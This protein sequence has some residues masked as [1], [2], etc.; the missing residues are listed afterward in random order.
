ME[1]EDIHPYWHLQCNLVRGNTFIWT[2]KLT[3]LLLQ[4]DIDCYLRI[5]DLLKVEVL[6]GRPRGTGPFAFTEPRSLPSAQGN[7][8]I[9]ASGRRQPSQWEGIDLTA[10]DIGDQGPPPSTAPAALQTTTT[11]R[12]RGRPKKDLA[13]GGTKA[14]KV[15]TGSGTTGGP[16]YRTLLPTPAPPAPPALPAGQVGGPSAPAWLLR[17]PP[18]Q[19]RPDDNPFGDDNHE[20]DLTGAP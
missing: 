5:H 8:R 2:Y 3:R 7:Q 11:A 10:E 18:G 14:K 4:D 17:A 15:N 12:K 13:A 16:Q 9:P 6:K 19:V 1:I 20:V